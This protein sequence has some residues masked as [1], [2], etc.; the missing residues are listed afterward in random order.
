MSISKSEFLDSMRGIRLLNDVVSDDKYLPGHDIV[1]IPASGWNA[2][3]TGDYTV[4]HDIA[5]T[6]VTAADKAEVAFAGTSLAI[7]DA[8]G[9]GH[10][11]TMAG[12]IRIRAVVAPVENL[13]AEIWITHGK[14]T[15]H[16][17]NDE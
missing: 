7:A 3:S 10:V 2:G 11:E 8:Y 13:T 6:S 15:E 17:G 5:A 16:A 9:I 1:S 4:Y 14:E 12:N